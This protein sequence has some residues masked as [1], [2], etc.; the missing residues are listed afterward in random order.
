MTA[1]LLKHSRRSS[2]K[3]ALMH[4]IG[5][6]RSALDAAEDL[7]GPFPG[8]FGTAVGIE[9]AGSLEQALRKRRSQ[10]EICKR[11]AVASLINMRVVVFVVYD[12]WP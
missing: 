9:I 12:S 10:T 1:A 6:G 4:G 2:C 3:V 7:N 5:L 8:A 11:T